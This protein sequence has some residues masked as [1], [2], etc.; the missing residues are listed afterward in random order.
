M[1][2]GLIAVIISIVTFCLWFL[3]SFRKNTLILLLIIP[4]I[5][6]SIIFGHSTYNKILG[7]PIEVTPT[8]KY[9]LVA[10]HA[11]PKTDI[12]L[13]IIK[14]GETTPRAYRIDYSISKRKKLFGI[15]RKL[16]KGD[17]VIINWPNKENDGGMFVLYKLPKP[18]WL[19][20]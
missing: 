17:V 5:F 10:F 20:K 4:V 19:K 9:R 2:Y 3:I 11:V 8:G 18:E 6:G 15:K 13:W 1:I 7:Y 14:K 16:R 12:Y